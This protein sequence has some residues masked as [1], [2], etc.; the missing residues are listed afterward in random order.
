MSYLIDS[1]CPLKKYC[2]RFG[3]IA[4]CSDGRGLLGLLES[5]SEA[6]FGLHL[7]RYS[8]QDDRNQDLRFLRLSLVILKGRNLSLLSSHINYTKAD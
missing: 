7:S 8:F 4:I 2:R 3:S 5:T 1:G 6:C